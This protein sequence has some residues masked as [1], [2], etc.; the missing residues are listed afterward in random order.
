L[1]HTNVTDATI[2]AL[3]SLRELESLSVFDMGHTGCIASDRSIAEAAPRLRRGNEDFGFAD[4]PV[5][6]KDKLVF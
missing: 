2:Q 6:L 5:S 3:G 4:V 1:T